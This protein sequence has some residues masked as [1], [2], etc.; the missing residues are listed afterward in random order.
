MTAEQKPLRLIRQL[1]HAPSAV[2]A[3]VVESTRL[4]LIEKGWPPDRAAWWAS[5]VGAV[6][7]LRWDRA[8]RGYDDHREEL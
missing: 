3:E 8:T 1:T 7:E 5:R 4:D 6:P 2:I